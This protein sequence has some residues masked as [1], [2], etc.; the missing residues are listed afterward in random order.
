MYLIIS[1]WKIE[2]PWE[3]SWDKKEVSITDVT[4]ALLSHPTYA[5]AYQN[6]YVHTSLG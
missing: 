5:V 4:V 1:I 2:F 3:E 6:H